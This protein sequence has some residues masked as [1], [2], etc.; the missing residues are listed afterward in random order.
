MKLKTL[1]ACALVCACWL[2][3]PAGVAASA[4]N[5]KGAQSPAKVSG[6]ERDAA[7]KVNKAKGAEA[8]LQAAAE[9]IRK[10]PQS[11]LR[12]QVA[13]VV[14][15]EINSTQDVDLKVSLL[16]TYLDFFQSPSEMEQANGMLLDIYIRSNR[17]ADALSAGSGWLEKHPDDIPTLRNLTI[18]AAAESI[19]G[20]VTL[21]PQ[22]LK[23]GAHAIE[24]LE[25]D[26]RPE[27]V[28]AAK[29]PQYKH[30]A[31]VSLYREMGVLSYT[32]GDKAAALPRFEKAA[33]LNST[34]PGVYLILSEL[35]YNKYA[36]LAAKYQAAPAGPSKDE[37]LKQVESSLDR[38]IEAYAQAI[39]ITDGN[40]QYQQANTVMRQDLEKYYKF[41]HKNSTDGLQQLI[42]KYKKPATQ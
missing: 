12:P 14:L 6:G 20:N 10:Y 16:K 24:L 32:T 27:T 23:Y 25:A 8:K 1:S 22:G 9:F 35:T 29:W 38:V 15:N 40:A 31:L 39:A 36:A 26:K 11:S 17:A 7:V 3:M 33:E 34:D 21:A 41:R 30:D 4:Q 42:D 13:G 18:L 28:D 37:M 2:A 5:N 19:K